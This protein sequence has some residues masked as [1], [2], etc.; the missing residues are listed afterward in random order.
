MYILC[1]A[2]AYVIMPIGKK[3]KNRIHKK[4]RKVENPRV[5]ALGFSIPFWEGG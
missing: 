5:A 4:V 2:T 3:D 1:F